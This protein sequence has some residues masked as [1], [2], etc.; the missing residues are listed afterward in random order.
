MLEQ[1]IIRNLQQTL[2]KEHV[3]TDKADLICYSYDATQQQFLPD[4]V[5]Y[6][7]TAEDVALVMKLANAENI[8]VFPRGAGSGF[9][10]GSLPTRGGIVLSTERMNRILE[11]DSENLVATVEPGVVTEQFQ[12]AV[13]K[14]GLF[15]PPDPASLKFSTLGGNVAECAGGPRCVKYGVTKDFIIGLEVVTPT[16]DIITTG[17]PTMKGVVGYDLTKLICGSEGTLGI[18]TRI[19]I[20]LLPLPEAK[21]TMLVMF[22]SIDG[23]ARAVSTIIGHKIIP[24]TLEFMDG[25]T[26]DCV[27]QATDLEVPEG[28]RA[29]LI[30][31]VDG[32]RE[33]LAKQVQK[34]QQL[35]QPLGVVETRSAETPEESEA[36][37]Q[38]RRSV[39]ASLRKV[40][41]D[42][43]NED[44]C[45]PR[46]KVPE[47]I[48]KVD[49]IAEKYQIPIVNF[50]HAGDG[51]IHVNVMI[52]KKVPG[53][54]ERAHK[55]I[56]E[57]F[58]G[59]LELGGTMSGEH[60]V[61][62]AKAPYIPLEISEKA[63]DYM[64][65]IKKALDPNNILNP[66][67]IF[68]D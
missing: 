16:G 30:I 64:K 58:K 33:F 60:G 10:G 67:K 68:L 52:D 59:A 49:A 31:E 3:S 47:M 19:V 65:T 11:I 54:L 1:R 23:A 32:D 15:Y 37:W 38:I 55:A 6:P 36:L 20:K 26:L 50:G 27:R 12:K 62:I 9:T 63:A 48:R 8:P 17:G 46:S 39:S 56:E 51:N 21:K 41:P 13:E 34:I 44:I 66:G 29:V 43:F 45:V 42:K 53:E 7:A 4:V 35:I 61:G 14:L 22:D 2:G 57:V 28:A 40:N 25:R 18:I 5:I 24:T